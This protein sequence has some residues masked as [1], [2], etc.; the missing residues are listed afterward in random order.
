MSELLLDFIA[1]RWEAVQ[2]CFLTAGGATVSKKQMGRN[3]HVQQTSGTP[4][5]YDLKA[6]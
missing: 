5:C 1:E 2:S 6:A 3:H 4:F